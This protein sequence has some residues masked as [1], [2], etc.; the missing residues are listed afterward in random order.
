V[1]PE[2]REALLAGYALGSLSDP[3][4]RDAERLIRNDASAEREYEAY[5]DLADM[6]AMSVPLRRADPSLRARLIEAARRTQSPWRSGPH[7]RRFLPAAGLAA[8]LV[9]VTVWA[10]SLQN[11][12][13]GLRSEQ[14]ALAAVVE[15]SAKRLD[16]LDQTTVDAQQAET[17]GLRLETAIRDQQ[18][19]LAVQAADDAHIV[20]LGADAAAHGA[21]GQY[22]Y[23]PEQSAGVLLVYELPPLPV[24][25]SYKVWLEDKDSAL[26]LAS[27]FLP[28]S[29]GD[30]T[31]VLAFDREQTPV[32]LFVVASSAGGSDGPVVL[33]GS[34]GN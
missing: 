10:V 25:A 32:R 1:T 5:L 33:R 8:A 29:N 14:S 19:L 24:G 12:I 6:I 16:T 30:A 20:T 2:E 18:T 27:T 4:A 26:V 23:S 11:T 17:L 9:L 28:T 7:W 15:A 21:H 3:D 34:M 31:V 22:I 13:S